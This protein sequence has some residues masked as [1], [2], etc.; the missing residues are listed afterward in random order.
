MYGVWNDIK[1]LAAK[2]IPPLAPAQQAERLDNYFRWIKRGE[3]AN[4]PG[5]D[6]LLGSSSGRLSDGRTTQGLYNVLQHLDEVGWQNVIELER[7]LGPRV[8]Q[9]PFGPVEYFERYV[10]L[11]LRNPDPRGLPIYRELKSLKDGATFGGRFGHEVAVDVRFAIEEATLGGVVIEERL[12]A[13][14]ARLQYFLRG[15]AHEMDAVVTALRRKLRRELGPD[16]EGLA[17]L[18]T[19]RPEGKNLPL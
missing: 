1:L 3:D 12:V 6:R 17:S 14:L 10:D 15:N 18:V 5:W 11:V 16:F 13:Q 9:T 7:G 8:R 19:I 2:A 4:I